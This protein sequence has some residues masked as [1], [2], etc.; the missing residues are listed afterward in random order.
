MKRI[1]VFCAS[2]I[3]F[4]TIFQE[5]AYLLGK[6][7]AEKQIELIYGGA[8]VGLMGAVA[9]GVLEHKGAATGILPRFLKEKEIAH[10]NL[11]QLIL[12]DTMHERKAMMGEMADGIIALPGGFGTME[13]LFE[14]LTWGQLGLHKKPIGILNINGFYN[15]LLSFIQ[16]VVDK[17]FMKE[18]Y[19]KLLLKSDNIDDLLN[20]MRLYKSPEIT[21]WG[22]KEK[23]V[24]G[25]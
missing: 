12:V 21:K 23:H 24:N 2:S 7:L 1:A 3:G 8:K 15:D 10:E 18:I 22:I 20:Q 17:G 25:E 14:M 11:T 6:T 9:D 4:E 19:Q 13:E 16:T 5:Q